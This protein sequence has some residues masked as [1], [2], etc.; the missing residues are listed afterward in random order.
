VWVLT[1]TLDEQAPFCDHPV[2]APIR[3]TA[4]CVCTC[5]KL[6]PESVEADLHLDMPRTHAERRYSI[7]IKDAEGSVLFSSV[8][9]WDDKDKRIALAQI[10]RLAQLPEV[11]FYAEPALTPHVGKKER[12]SRR[13]KGRLDPELS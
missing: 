2:T 4:I 9:Y 6:W 3:C 5:E 10:T 1:Q 13:G 12:R 11:N 8:A 7:E